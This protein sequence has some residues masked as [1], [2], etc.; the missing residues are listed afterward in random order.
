MADRKQALAERTLADAQL[1]DPSLLG[2]DVAVAMGER[3]L[4]RSGR[5]DLRPRADLVFGHDGELL[6]ML[7]PPRA[8]PDQERALVRLVLALQRAL[9]WPEPVRRKQHAAE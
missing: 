3:L 2:L 4:T 9:R 7:L 1:D 5:G 6:V 8:T